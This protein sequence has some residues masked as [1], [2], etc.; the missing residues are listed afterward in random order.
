MQ[1]RI[2]VNHLHSDYFVG[3]F[4]LCR[5]DLSKGTGSNLFQIPKEV[6]YG[7]SKGSRP[8]WVSDECKRRVLYCQDRCHQYQAVECMDEKLTCGILVFL[9]IKAANLVFRRQFH[10]GDEHA[11][12]VDP[13]SIWAI[14][15]CK[16]KVCV[17]LLLSLLSLPS[18]W[19]IDGHFMLSL[20]VLWFLLSK[21]NEGWWLKFFFFYA[22]AAWKSNHALSSNTYH[23]VNEC[24]IL[25]GV[26]VRDSIVKRL[27]SLSTN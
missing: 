2:L 1:Q 22:A 10:C 16:F 19:E 27:Q 25:L 12:R 15:V 24:V 20:F 6:M 17:C 8:V 4:A 7:S 21:C 11:F 14:I 9:W 13:D 23:T 18:I 5:K 3:L 26:F